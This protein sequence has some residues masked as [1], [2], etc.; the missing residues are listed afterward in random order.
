[1]TKD[2]VSLS[3]PPKPE[4]VAVARLAVS[5]IVSRMGFTAEEVEDI[6]V[7]LSEACTNAVQY[8]YTKKK[9]N[10]LV[11]ISI[12]PK[13]TAVTIIVADTGAGFDAAHP[14][15]RPIKDNDIHMGLG[16]VFIKNLMDVVSIVSAKGKVTKI[17]MT[18]KIRK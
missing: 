9:T 13:K 12:I 15:R 2:T 10:A 6:K 8:A 14:P 5:G 1:M 11:Q 17:T 16:L 4:Y 3:I 7:A 18:K